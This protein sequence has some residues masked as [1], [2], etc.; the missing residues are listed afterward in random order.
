MLET[1][2]RNPWRGKRAYFCCIYTDRLLAYTFILKQE[3]DGTQEN[4]FKADDKKSGI[5]PH[6]PISAVSEFPFLIHRI[7][8]NYAVMWF[9]LGATK[10]NVFYGPS[11]QV[12]MEADLQVMESTESSI[13]I[14]AANPDTPKATGRGDSGSPLFVRYS[15]E[16]WHVIGVVSIGNG[17]TTFLPK[18]S[19]YS[20]WIN[21]NIQDG[22]MC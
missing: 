6:L 2:L 3:T 12:L 5:S 10:I 8:R 11:S 15:D 14:G 13:G 17:I 19:H 21:E 18:V 9:H 1:T 16:R 20:S 7:K 4:V 22:P